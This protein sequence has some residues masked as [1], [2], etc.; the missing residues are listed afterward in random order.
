MQNLLVSV[1]RATC[2]VQGPSGIRICEYLMADAVEALGVG[3][4]MLV[5]SV[6]PG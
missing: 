5:R 3:G 6:S 2:P 4:L 1:I